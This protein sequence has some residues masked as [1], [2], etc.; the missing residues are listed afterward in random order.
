MTKIEL[1]NLI[2]S[3]A[4]RRDIATTTLCRLAVGNNRLLRN[5]KSGNS[6]TLDVAER[7]VTYIKASSG[8][9]QCRAAG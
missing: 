3:E 8:P 2:E 7:F 9:K 1:I 5:L 4:K 6:C